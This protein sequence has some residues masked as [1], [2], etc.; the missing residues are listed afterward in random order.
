MRGDMHLR[1]VRTNTAVCQRKSSRG[2]EP[3][4]TCELDPE[5]PHPH[6]PLP[7]LKCAF[8]PHCSCTR[9]YFKDATL[10]EQC[11]GEIHWMAHMTEP[12]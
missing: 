3:W 7:P 2:H 6:S 9:K 5:A 1:G 8:W 12:C 11:A 4:L 10:E